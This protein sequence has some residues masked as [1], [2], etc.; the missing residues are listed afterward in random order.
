MPGIAR[1]PLQ[2][3]QKNFDIIVIGGGIYGVMTLLEA[4]RRGLR[5][6]LLEK[7]DFG[8][9]TSFN[10]LRI[11]HGGLRYLQHLDLPRFR[12]SVAERSWFLKCFPD[13]VRPLPCLMPLYGNG[14]RRPVIL[15]TAIMMNHILSYHR[16]NGLSPER[17]MPAGGVVNAAE[18]CMLF[19]N[20][21]KEGLKGAALWYDA[22]VPD[23]HALIME[24][25][26]MSCYFG[27]FALNYVEAG[28]L[29]IENGRVAGVKAIDR[30][31]EKTYE[32]KSNVVVNAA[33]PWSRKMAVRYDRDEPA[34]FRPSLAW[35]VL[36]TKK[37]P[38]EY[39]LAVAANRPDSQLYFLV[40]WNGRLLAGTGHAAWHDSVDHPGVQDHQLENF[41]ANINAAAPGL[42]AET[43]DVVHVF[44]GLLPVRKSGST[45]L[46]HREV[47]LTHKKNGGPEGLYTISGIKFTTAR[48]VAEKLLSRIFG[49]Q[50]KPIHEIR[51]ERQDSLGQFPVGW[52]PNGQ[53][54]K[55]DLRRI[56]RTQAVRHLD[57]LIFRR[58][59]LWQDPSLAMRIASDICGLFEWDQNRREEETIRLKTHFDS[60][61]FSTF[62]EKMTSHN[63]T[64]EQNSLRS[65]LKN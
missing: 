22:F 38:S 49:E 64:A 42:R 46:T 45:H 7:E 53:Q 3:A 27:G 31:N 54:W 34:L 50:L 8:R 55:E 12:E 15:Q 28:D 58:T 25:I 29:L 60:F 11:I 56:I 17:K 26:R 40:P 21:V 32:F 1:N 18:T 33:G 37:P 36:L 9:H 44:K 57:D 47:I 6:L 35:N 30:E 39:A 41:L 4:S 20:V 23:S 63:I 51:N 52:N 13:F 16:N 5:V 65:V 61:A 48:R 14:L 2:A 24:L 59:T 43:K 19:P 10:S 62:K